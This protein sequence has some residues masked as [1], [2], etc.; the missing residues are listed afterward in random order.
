[1]ELRAPLV[2][3]TEIIV[4]VMENEDSVPRK[5]SDSELNHKQCCIRA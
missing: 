4:V 2:Q 3:Y 5:K 1:M